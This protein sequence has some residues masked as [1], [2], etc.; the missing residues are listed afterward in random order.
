MQ[1]CSLRAR[2]RRTGTHKVVKANDRVVDDLASN[3]PGGGS[4]S[5]NGAVASGGVVAVVVV[6]VVM[7]GG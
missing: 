1:Y 5:R 7:V 3:R 6:V 4:L 2:R